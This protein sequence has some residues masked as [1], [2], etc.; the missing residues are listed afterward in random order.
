LRE[1][2]V[3]FVQSLGY[4]RVEGYFTIVLGLYEDDVI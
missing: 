3:V 2:H 1:Y 4:A